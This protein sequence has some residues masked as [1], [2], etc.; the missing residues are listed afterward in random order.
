MSDWAQCDF[1]GTAGSVDDLLTQ[2][3]KTGHA[4][5]FDVW[6]DLSRPPAKSA[7]QRTSRFECDI[8]NTKLSPRMPGWYREI[9]GW[10]KVRIKGANAIFDRQETGRML[11]AECYAS[12]TPDSNNKLF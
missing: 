12:T 3:G 5:C 8:C 7:K 9:T 2:F 6:H 1:C 4:D 11:C 10:E